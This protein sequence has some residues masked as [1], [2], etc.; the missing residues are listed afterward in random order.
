MSAASNGAPAAAAAAATASEPRVHPRHFHDGP[1]PQQPPLKPP[2]AAAAG[3]PAEAQPPAVQLHR[4]AM[5]SVLAFCT[6]RELVTASAVSR[7]WQAAVLSMA[8]VQ[9]GVG[10]CDANRLTAVC[11]SP[12][13]RHASSIAVYDRP[14]SPSVTLELLR[15][16]I[17]HLRK[18][19]V[20]LGPSAAPLHFPP[21]LIELELDFTTEA[22]VDEDE[23]QFAA[24][25]NTTVGA[26]AGLVLLEK[27][28]LRCSLWTNEGC[29]LAALSQAP[30]LRHLEVST[31]IVQSDAQV[32][33]LRALTELESVHFTDDV[34]DEALLGRLLAQPHNLHWRDLG[35]QTPVTEAV[36]PLLLSL[37]LNRLDAYLDMPDAEFITQMPN[38]TALTIQQAGD[39]QPDGDLILQAVGRC[40]NL[41]KL[42]ID[43]SY[44][45]TSAELGAC[46]R[47]LPQL[48]ALC[49]FNGQKLTTLSSLPRTLTSLELVNF[50]LRVPMAELQHVL[51]LRELRSLRLCNV[52]DEPL[53][54]AGEL[55]FKPPF[56]W[57]RMP[58]LTYFEHSW[59]APQANPFLNPF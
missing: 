25:F 39:M 3:E 55:L 18:L 16:S 27:L 59:Q 5:E 48:Q 43:G 56:V 41:R 26:V 29:S 14:A 45:F 17:P 40:E 10:R 58:D 9:R 38:L 57:D 50:T 31:H 52:F 4:H 23:E 21:Q 42:E 44:A 32:N 51:S 46:L 33:E 28:V 47:R 20:V 35:D 2:A 49:V 15:Q 53:G 30:S 54:T 7:D 11:S 34:I 24:R 36:V 19:D 37:P 22:D 13:R 6:L 12:L 8:P 1:N